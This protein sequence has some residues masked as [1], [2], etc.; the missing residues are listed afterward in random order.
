MDWSNA[1]FKVGFYFD[2]RGIS[3]LQEFL[4]DLRD[5]QDKQSRNTFEKIVAHI[6]YLAENGFSL[7]M[8]YARPIVDATVPLRELRPGQYRVFYAH[9]NGV[10][11]LL[12]YYMKKS[13][14]IPPQEI[15]RAT[16]NYNDQIS[17]GL[18]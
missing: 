3:E 8:P 16:N 18:K 13:Q 14:D 15:E 10:F 5:R 17:R 4:F 12:H 2:S 11:I 1:K 7:R 6:N 9:I